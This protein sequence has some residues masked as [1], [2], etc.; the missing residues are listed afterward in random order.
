M[1]SSKLS[2]HVAAIGSIG[3]SVNE[4]LLVNLRHFP[5]GSV[6]L[7]AVAR[8]GSNV[9]KDQII[10]DLEVALVLRSW[11]L[12]K[13]KSNQLHIGSR[14]SRRNEPLEQSW[15]SA[16][17]LITTVNNNDQLL[18]TA[19][20]RSQAALQSTPEDVVSLGLAGG[21]LAALVGINQDLQQ[22]DVT[23]ALL[24][25]L[26]QDGFGDGMRGGFGWDTRIYSNLVRTVI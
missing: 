12:V 25:E 5:E 3:D 26:G 13:T 11:V 18:C 15:G 8:E 16:R 4:G 17:R 6:H 24:E 23:N 19:E 9:I 21:R 10:G 7:E 2:P 22:L 14:V 1:L 20:G